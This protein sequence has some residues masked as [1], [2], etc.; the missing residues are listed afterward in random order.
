M[1]ETTQYYDEFIRYYNMALDQQI[2]CNVADVEPYG[3]LKHV[4]SNMNDDLMHYV[5]LYDVVERKYAGFSQIVNDCFYG[6]TEEHPYWKKMQAGIHTRQREMVAKAWTG[7]HKDF[8]LPEWLY[9][10]ILHRVT[11]SAI[12]YSTKP[13]GYHNTLLLHLHQCK[14]IE[15]MTKLVNHYPEPFYT[16]IGYQFP[17][18]PKPPSGSKYKRSGDY[19]LTEFAPKLA[20]D[21]A[22]WLNINGDKKDLREIGEYMFDWNKSNGMNAY[23]FQY[24]AVIADI[25]DWYPKFVNHESMF[26]YGTNAVECISYLAN[27]LVK[28][29]QEV[30]L[31]KVMSKIYEDT[32]SVPYNAEDVCCDF[33]RWIE[34]YIRPGYHY[35]HLDFDSVWNSSIIK[36]HPFGR[37]KAMLELGIVKTFNG[38]KSHPS[39]D[40]ILQQAGL[41]V[42]DY[43]Q[44]VK[45]LYT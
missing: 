24:A 39:D 3:M 38:M 42:K 19:Y 23:K 25:A 17:S 26:Y 33:I 4:D 37:Q 27:P 9:I 12:N 31:D 43:K 15:E 34:N 6:W 10:F 8:D 18:F 40:T 14:N 22:E 7:K 5:E 11:G 21:M 35:D 30:F 1:I 32:G 41:T 45:D 29:K 28:M 16:S 20:R 36:D 13:S 2:K 44:K